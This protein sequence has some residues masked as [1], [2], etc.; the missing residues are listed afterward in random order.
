MLTVENVQDGM[1]S[2]KNEIRYMGER[3]K[4]ITL[5]VIGF[6]FYQYIPFSAVAGYLLG[7]LFTTLF[8]LA[9]ISTAII[10]F[11]YKTYGFDPMVIFHFWKS[12]EEAK[13]T[14]K[15]NEIIVLGKNREQ[16]EIDA[17]K[18]KS[19]DLGKT[20]SE[21]GSAIN[22]EELK[23]EIKKY[24]KE[25]MLNAQIE[26]VKRQKALELKVKEQRDEEEKEEKE[27]EAKVLKALAVDE[28]IK[29]IEKDV[30]E[31]GTNGCRKCDKKKL[32]DI[33]EVIH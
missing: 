15:A 23:D 12:L 1:S 31:R 7:G 5:F 6:V 16:D 22:F 4:L 25:K 30:R 14:K 32:V 11:L 27:K 17:L 21:K 26:D 24:E 10:T 19:E 13:K 2:L 28:R 20:I 9:V 33:G 29:N 8:Y 18:K 3:E